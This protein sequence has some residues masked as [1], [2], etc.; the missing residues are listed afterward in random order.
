MVRR[1][2]LGVDLYMPWMHPLPDFTRGDSPYGVNLIEL[3]QRLAKAA[4]ADQPI[5]ILD[6]GANIGDSAAQ[7]LAVV[8][9]RILCVDGD[10]YWVTFLR[11]NLGDDSRVA[12]E[13]ALLVV[14]EEEWTNV[15]TVRGTG[16]T[17][18]AEGDG[19]TKLTAMSIAALRRKHP[20]F[21]KV[22]LIKSDT[23]GFDPTLVPALAQEWSESGPVL[24][25]EFDPRLARAAGID[26]PGTL[27]DELA[28]LGY[29]KLAVWESGGHP[30]GTLDVADAREAARSIDPIPPGLGYDYWDVA[31][32][33]PDDDIAIASFDAL[34]RGRFSPRGPVPA[35]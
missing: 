19:G 11:K 9:A 26:D 32:C 14:S 18:F 35:T 25:F 22:R 7:I 15:S 12:I 21:D 10:P 30:L 27:W 24:F 31:A 23:D 6:V 8:D 20:A 5:R 16:T 3:T 29:T 17:R 1:N 2:V 4:A 34:V 28:R 33:R 13:E